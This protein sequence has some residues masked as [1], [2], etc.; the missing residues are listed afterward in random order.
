[1]KLYR[2]DLIIIGFTAIILSVLADISVIYL[3]WKYNKVKISETDQEERVFFTRY[4]RL[5]GQRDYDSC[6]KLLADLSETFKDKIPWK[7]YQLPPLGEEGVD[8]LSNMISRIPAIPKNKKSII[9]R[10]RSPLRTNYAIPFHLGIPMMNAMNVER[11]REIL[12]MSKIRCNSSLSL[13]PSTLH[14]FYWSNHR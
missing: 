7:Q 3:K 6:I 8:L 5:Y 4:F 10:E 9:M 11:K 2:R 1:M 13:R 12:R 14:I